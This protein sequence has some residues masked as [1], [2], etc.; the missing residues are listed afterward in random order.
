MLGGRAGG[1]SPERSG[2]LGFAL[3]LRWRGL[4]ADALHVAGFA[5]KARHLGEAAALDADVGEDRID[6]WRLNAVAQRRIDHLVGGAAPASTTAAADA[7][8]QTVDMQDADA[9]D[10]LHRLDALAH[11]ALDAV[12]QLAAE[13]RVA[14]LIGKHVLGLVEQ[15]LPLGLDRRAHAFGPG[16]DALLLGFLLGDQHLDRLAP[17]GDLAVAHGDDAFGGLGGVR[18]GV[19]G[20]RLRGRLFQRFLIE[21]DRLLHQHRLDLLLAVDLQ[22][23]QFALAPDAGL[24]EPAVRGDAGALD[25]LVRGD[26]G[27]LQ[28]LNATDFELLDHAPA[29]QPGRF[30][31]LL[32]RYFGGLDVAAGDDFG[33]LDLPVGVDALGAFRR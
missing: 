26:L 21:N 15:L 2:R 1:P 5:N 25:F 7:A 10:F 22:F 17:L 29:L 32:L 24:V 18:L 6:Q 28:R 3:L 33:L 14:R 12:E 23:A 11:D 9:L 20:L 8:G 16:G 19:L 13:Q 31:R 30:Q 4:L 27:F